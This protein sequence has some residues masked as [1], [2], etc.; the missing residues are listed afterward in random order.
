MPKAIDNIKR[1]QPP[2]KQGDQRSVKKAALVDIPAC[3]SA[4]AEEAECPRCA[5]SMR[6][7]ANY[8]RCPNCG[9]KESCCF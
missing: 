1:Q 2:S 3:A 9:Y 5:A 7:W 8:Y 4:P 6:L